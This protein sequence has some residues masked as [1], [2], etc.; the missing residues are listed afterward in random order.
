M[1]ESSKVVILRD[2]KIL[3]I[4]RIKND[5]EYFV[6]P[7][8]SIEDGETPE[9]AAIREVKEETNFDVELDHLLWKIQEP[10]KGDEKTGYYFLV[11]NFRGELTLGEPEIERRNEKNVYLFEW[12]T[13]DEIKKYLIYP[14]ELKQKILDTFYN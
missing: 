6:L 7:G 4:H 11:K 9:A 14:E 3:F 5:R 2:N 13:V 8:G 12:L 10:M 1:K